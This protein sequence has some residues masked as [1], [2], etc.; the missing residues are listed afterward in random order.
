MPISRPRP[1]FLTR[2]DRTPVTT[3]EGIVTGVALQVRS[4]REGER[5]LDELTDTE[6]PPV[7]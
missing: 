2:N 1:R 6:C 7:D 4:D 3:P 5:R